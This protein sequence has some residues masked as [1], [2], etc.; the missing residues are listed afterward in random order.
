MPVSYTHLDV[1]KRQVKGHTGHKVV[2]DR[3]D[4]AVLYL[5]LFALL[6]RVVLPQILPAAYLLCIDLAATCWFVTFATL[7]WRYLPYVWRARVDGRE[8]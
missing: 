8:H 4:R 7:A 6:I 5:M 3:G 2:F 1:Y